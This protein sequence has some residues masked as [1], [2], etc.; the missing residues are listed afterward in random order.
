MEKSI[1]ILIIGANY[2]GTMATAQRLRNLF[3]PLLKK[4]NIFVSNLLFNSTE[5]PEDNEIKEVHFVNVRYSK[6]NPVDFILYHWNSFKYIK[7]QKKRD[8]NNILFCYGYPIINNILILKYAKYKDYKIVFNIEENFLLHT[9]RKKTIFELLKRY[10]LK[11]LLGQI[12]RLGSLCF[13]ISSQLMEYCN[14]I[15]SGKIPVVE[16]PVSVDIDYVQSFKK[17]IKKEKIQVFYGGS[18]GE[19]D[20][21]PFLIEGFSQACKKANN[22]ELILTGKIATGLEKQVFDQINSSEEKDKIKYLGCLTTEKY[23]ETMA[24]ADILCMLRVNTE[25]ANAGFPFKLCEYLASGNVIIATKT[26]DVTRYIDSTEKICLVDAE[27][28]RAITTVILELAQ[29]KNI[30]ENNVSLNIAKKY[31]DSELV[32]NMLYKNILRL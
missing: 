9:L 18:F 21:I 3:N 7:Q 30:T 28:T 25:F 5:V 20:G 24:N 15:C 29:R 2:Y 10:S 19:K 22:L 13:A 23:Y 8:C 1:H 16:L 32:A 14:S 31:F 11:Y 27:D 17:D 26:S 4:D 12:P 6:R